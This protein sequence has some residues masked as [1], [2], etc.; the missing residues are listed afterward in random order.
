MQ[1][2]LTEW[3][4]KINGPDDL[5]LVEFLSSWCSV[6]YFVQVGTISMFV[7]RLSNC[8]HTRSKG[9]R[10]SNFIL[11]KMIKEVI[12][13]D[14][15]LPAWAIVGDLFYPRQNEQAG[16]FVMYTYTGLLWG[17]LTN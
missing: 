11:L 14:E 15:A 5:W 3:G 8:M 17:S 12:Y 13:I 6:V 4:L 2:V 16:Y 9:Q 1:S 7:R 10:I